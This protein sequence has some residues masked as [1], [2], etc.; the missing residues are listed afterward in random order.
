MKCIIKILRYEKYKLNTKNV[1]KYKNY[2]QGME[3]VTW[4]Y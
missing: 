4:V 3:N 2:D 1:I